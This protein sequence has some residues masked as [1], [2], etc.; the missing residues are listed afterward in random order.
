MEKKIQCI[1][2]SEYCIFK[3]LRNYIKINNSMMKDIWI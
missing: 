2:E 1:R 3:I